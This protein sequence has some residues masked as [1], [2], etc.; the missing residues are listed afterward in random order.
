MWI[1]GS[2]FAVMPAKAGIQSRGPGFAALD[3][4]FRGND[5]EEG[6]DIFVTCDNPARKGREE[7][8]H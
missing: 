6:G 1:P 3:S 7:T 5:T 8:G 4:R 2:P